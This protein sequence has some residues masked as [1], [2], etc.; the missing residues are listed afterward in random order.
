MGSEVIAMSSEAPFSELLRQQR[1]A[2]GYSQEDLAERAGLSVSAIGSLEQG[3]RRAPHRDTVRFL[4]DALG[5]SESVRRQLEEAAARARGR[6]PR[7][8]SGLPTSLTSFIERH[9]LD[10]LKALLSDHRLL[11]ITGSPGIGKTR[12][13]IELARRIEDMYDE[14]W[15]VDLLPVRDGKFV[16]SQVALRLNVPAESDDDL[17]GIVR[18]IQSRHTLL[19]ID[20]C[21]HVV[22]DVASVV[23]KLLRSCSLLTVLTTSREALAL[24]A[25]LAYRLPS[26]DATVA[27][28]LFLAR[29]QQR[30][31]T[32]SLDM[33]RLAVVADICK[34]LD[35][36]PLA[37]ELAASRVSTLG[38]EA[39]RG[40]LK[41]GVTLAGSRD[42]PARQ[43]TMN[44]TI[45]WSYD[46]L[47]DVETLLFRR[48]SVMIG[49]F[50]LEAAEQ[51]GSGES[52]PVQAV[53]DALSNVV[54]KSLINVDHIGTSTRYR[55]LES[56]RTFALDRLRYEGDLENTML[57][58]MEWLDQK[59]AVFDSSPPEVIIENCSDLDNVRAAVSWALSNSSYA[60]IASAANIVIRF[61]SAWYWNFRQADARTLGLALLER[62]DDRDSPEIVGWLIACIAPAI[63]GA[64]LLALAFRAI[65]L[66][67]EVG[68][69]DAAAYLQ[70]RIAEIEWRRG[71]VA[72]AERHLAGASGLLNTR[73]LRRTQ[74]GLSAAM[75]SAYVRCLLNDFL[76]ARACL[77]Q[78]EIPSGNVI[79][80]DA[81]IVLAEIE[82]REG[83]AEK[84]IDLLE[85]SASDVARYP[86]AS[87]LEVL[88]F[89]NLARYLFFV[90]D[91][92]SSE[93][94]LRRSLRLLV[95]A[96][97]FGFL[98]MALGY[99]RYAAA[100]AV[101][102]GHADFA[103]R[104]LA[105]CGA[106]DER[107]GHV[108]GHDAL[109]CEMALNAVGKQLSRERIERLR[110]QGAGEDVYALLEEFLAQPAAA[111]N[112]RASA[113]SSP[114]AAS[115][116]RSSPN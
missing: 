88:I 79:E 86:N 63:A 111:D 108:S 26:M 42:L 107:N 64:E 8:D 13:A 62:L 17:S 16:T 90:R 68:R 66:L 95:S 14:T 106:T 84:A 35:G 110:V 89:G 114:R 101:E 23:E 25:E 48:L 53:A 65:P 15:F 103:V 77:Q 67:K 78:L 1:R 93:D 102:S 39:L 41:G 97:H 51:V 28:H 33:E 104:L 105:S 71:N 96:R 109:P 81:H 21:E 38:L 30:D 40:R 91:V 29:V 20:N 46:L 72:S 80:V 7:G 92:G 22:A 60:T 74:A 47:S 54:E 9:E 27:S 115:M 18:R 50:T 44:T 100:F 58:L 3:L 56:I 55:F 32:W 4:A 73:E 99:A 36:I 83:H 112:A 19:V 31:P 87:H 57:R 49:A 98:Y 116:T 6:Q 37:I 2:A 94:A 75:T 12:I 24:S 59:A 70:V 61:A 43:Q 52:L 10:E 76:G 11:T 82:F 69:Q 45:A 34:N 5:V 113:T 85:K